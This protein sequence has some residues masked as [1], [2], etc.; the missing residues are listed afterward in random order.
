MAA[1][2][3]PTERTH[4]AAAEFNAWLQDTL[5]TTTTGSS[6]RLERLRDWER[7]APHA[8]TVHP[9][10]EHLLPLLVVAATASSPSLSSSS[11]DDGGGG[12]PSSSSAQVIYDSS[13]TTTNDANATSREH[14]VS[15][16]LFQ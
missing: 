3:D 13:A 8:R 9:R 16:F 2:F 1:F 6:E 5:L 11:S 15:S 7:R 12:D 14:A 10:E 4:R